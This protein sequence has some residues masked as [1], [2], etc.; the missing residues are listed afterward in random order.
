M[1]LQIKPFI[2]L[3]VLSLK[4]LPFMRADEEDRRIGS[5]S[6]RSGLST[7]NDIEGFGLFSENT[8]RAFGD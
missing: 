4:C 8:L 5:D 2:G 7:S 1:I 6:N 3:S